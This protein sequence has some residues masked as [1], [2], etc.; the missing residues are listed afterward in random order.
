MGKFTRRAFITTGFVAGAGLVVGVALRPGNRA[1]TID[2]DQSAGCGGHILDLQIVVGIGD[3][4]R[5]H[6]LRQ[7]A[8]QQGRDQ[9]RFEYMFEEETNQRRHGPCQRHEEDQ[10]QP[11]LQEQQRAQA[12]FRPA[13]QP[14]HPAPHPR[15]SPAAQQ[16][17]G[18]ETAHQDPD[19]PQP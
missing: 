10:L 1:K 14:V 3:Q 13:F 8:G 6:R 16:P 11:P 17:R 15:R 12:P 5:I 9:N 7:T 19:L 18:N 4:Q 2:E